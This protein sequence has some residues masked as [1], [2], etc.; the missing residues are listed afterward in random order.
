VLDEVIQR[1]KETLAHGTLQHGLQVVTAEA[2]RPRSGLLPEGKHCLPEC[3]E[4]FLHAII[5]G[6]HAEALAGFW[7][8]V[9]GSRLGRV[10]G[11]QRPQDCRIFR[12]LH[13]I[14]GEHVEGLSYRSIAD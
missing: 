10:E 7:G 3:R 14:G 8:T 6:V 4:A 5:G 2:R 9:S 11:L 13:S 1:L 12:I